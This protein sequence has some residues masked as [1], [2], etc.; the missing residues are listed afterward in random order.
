MEHEDI[1]RAVADHA[2]VMIW[3]SDPDKLR[4]YL[5][6]R[7]LDFTGRPAEAELGDGWIHGIHPDDRRKIRDVCSDNFD[8]RQEYKIEYRLRRHDGEFC[9]VC[10]TCVPMYKADGLFAGY[11]GSCLDINDSKLS[12]ETL[13]KGNARLIEA[14]E[15]ERT[16]IAREL[17]DDI[18]SSLAILGIELMRAGQTVSGSPGKKHPGIQEVYQKLQEIA[19]RIS[20]LSHQL[21]SPMLEYMGLAKA[22]AKEC[23]EF[24]EKFHLPVS[25]ACNDIPARLDPAIA[26]GFFRVVQESL[27]NAAKHSR[28]AGVAVEMIAEGGFITLQVSDDGIGFDVEQSRLAPGI[29]LISMRERMRLIG[30]VFEI[31]STPGKGATIKCRAPLTRSDTQ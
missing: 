4:I 29:G 11:I 6:R 18:G 25:C 2:P 28:A 13:S 5:N 12:I 10:D 27:H 23:R 3:I 15:R 8:R 16:S 1:Y 19:S 20:H 9:W 21:H 31:L 7:W 14:Q 22:A 17:H 24:S 30:G 26:L